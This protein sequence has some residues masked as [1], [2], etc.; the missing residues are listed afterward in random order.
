MHFVGMFDPMLLQAEY[1]SARRPSAAICGTAIAAF[2][3][4]RQA[5]IGA[6]Q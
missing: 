4:I 6:S 2:A 5:L 3:V 1:R